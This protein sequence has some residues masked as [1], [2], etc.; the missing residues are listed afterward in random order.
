M[1]SE[2]LIEILKTPTYNLIRNYNEKIEFYTKN[3]NNEDIDEFNKCSEKREK[4]LDVWGGGMS[5]FFVMVIFINVFIELLVLWFI[6]SRRKD[7]SEQM[8]ILCIILWIVS[9]WI[10]FL[11]IILII[12]LLIY[13][14]K[15]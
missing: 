3:K 9:W 6:I 1:E 13:G 2:S 7:L 11:P 5:L 14:K 8:F 12:L 4:S 10:P 15:M